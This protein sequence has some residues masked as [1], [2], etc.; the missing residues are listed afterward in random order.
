[1]VFVV[2]MNPMKWTSQFPRP[3]NSKTDARSLA[4][5]LSRCGHAG[6]SLAK[7]L[8]GIRNR[9]NSGRRGVKTRVKNDDQRSDSA[10][11]DTIARLLR[12][13]RSLL[14]AGYSA[15]KGIVVGS[16]GTYLTDPRS[17][18]GFIRSFLLRH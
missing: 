14:H 18:W 11:I 5:R 10:L 8:L 6:R 16:E 12:A 9:S 15:E 3:L 2:W 13:W 1:M 4:F 7:G 17:N